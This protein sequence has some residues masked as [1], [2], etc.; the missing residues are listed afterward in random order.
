VK[1]IVSNFL[2]ATVV[3]G[4]SR[5]GWEVR[6]RASSFGRVEDINLSG[7]RIVVTGPTSGLG[8]ETAR[9][10][11]TAGADL[12][13]VGRDAH[14]TDAAAADVDAL[15]AGLVETVIADMGDLEAVARAARSIAAAGTLHA[16]VHNAGALVKERAVSAQGYETTVASHVLGPHLMTRVLGDALAASSGRVITVSSGGMYT[17]PLPRVAGSRTLEMGEHNWD[18][19]RQYAIAKRAQ[20]TLNEMWALERPDVWCAAMHPGWADTPGV[21]TSLPVFRVV[22]RPLLRTARQGADTIAWLAAVEPVPGGSGGFWC[23]REVRPIHRLGRT[24]SSDTPDRRRD[25]W[26][27]CTECT[28]AYVS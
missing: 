25:L 14:R 22:T 3:G 7:R 12:V 1:R 16:L 18:G 13:L 19:T 27:W 21:K 6:S 10:L 9:M 8:L 2:D 15:G 28:D 23:D 17:A 11:A 24:R 26:R 20:V 4:F 5:V